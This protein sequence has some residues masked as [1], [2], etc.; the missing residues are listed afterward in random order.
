MDNG[1]N[2]MYIFIIAIW[3]SMKNVWPM[4]N[5]LI[6]ESEFEGNSF[7]ENIFLAG[8]L[9]VLKSICLFL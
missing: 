8:D 4:L 5:F 1:H 7:W 2:Y 6:L 9:E 3:L